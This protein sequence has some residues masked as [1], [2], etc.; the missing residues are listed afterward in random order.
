MDDYRGIPEKKGKKSRLKDSSII[1]LIVCTL[2]L[3]TIAIS[4]TQFETINWR[5]GIGV[6]HEGEI[7]P[8]MSLGSLNLLSVISPDTSQRIPPI[9]VLTPQHYSGVHIG[10]NILVKYDHSTQQPITLTKDLSTTPDG[11]VIFTTS[12]ATKTADGFW[13]ANIGGTSKAEH[14]R[15]VSLKVGTE[16]INSTNMGL[17]LTTSQVP[18]TTISSPTFYDGDGALPVS[19]TAPTNTKDYRVMVYKMDTGRLHFRSF[20]TGT[21]INI[22]TEA[23]PDD[24]IYYVVVVPR[25]NE[26][27]T[28]PATETLLEREVQLLG[29][30]S[31]ARVNVQLETPKQIVPK[32]VV[33]APQEGTKLNIKDGDAHFEVKVQNIDIGV[34]IRYQFTVTNLTLGGTS[35]SSRVTKDQSTGSTTSATMTIRQSSMDGEYG[36]YV[37]AWDPTMTY[38]AAPRVL[39][40][41]NAEGSPRDPKFP[42][43]P[44]DDDDQPELPEDPKIPEEKGIILK[45]FSTQESYMINEK[46]S[47]TI[48]ATDQDKKAIDDL[49][50]TVNFRGETE[51]EK[52]P[53]GETTVDYKTKIGTPGTYTMKVSTTSEGYAQVAK[54]L[55]IVVRDEEICNNNGI[56]E[57]ERGENH[58]NCPNDCKESP[59]TNG[60]DNGNGLPGNGNGLPGNGDPDDKSIIDQILEP[61]RENSTIGVILVIMFLAILMFV[62]P[63]KQ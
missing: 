24:G 54:V 49:V 12:S 27:V 28:F 22:P 59:P 42:K 23:F 3:A 20:P 48:T 33:L 15:Y 13:T 51:V 40:R 41:L 50:Y 11:I 43:V 55:E 29:K 30:T 7:K 32:P 25:S 17:L 5:L 53:K 39:V 47:V 37:D 38:L 4:S 35:I 1:I 56:C 45:L 16:E 44:D 10:D 60:N 57:P 14:N 8:L 58:I 34:P 2:F 46:I 31:Y 18:E 19:W 21:S 61:I 36:L 6:T 9:F 63:K 52:F 62:I 26:T